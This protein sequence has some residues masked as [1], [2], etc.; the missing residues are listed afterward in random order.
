MRFLNGF[1][2]TVYLL[3]SGYGSENLQNFPKFPILWSLK[4][5]LVSNLRM[6]KPSLRWYYDFDDID[7]AIMANADTYGTDNNLL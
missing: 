6:Y 3:A 1:G 5:I 4:L 7:E 2:N